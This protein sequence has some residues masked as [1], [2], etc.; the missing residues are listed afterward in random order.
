MAYYVVSNELYHHGILGQKWGIR[1][2][3]NPDGSLTEAGKKRYGESDSSSS[4]SYEKA[5]HN[6][7]KNRAI[8]RR[9]INDELNKNGKEL[10]ESDEKF[11]TLGDQLSKDYDNYYKKLVNDPDF[12]RQFALKIIRDTNHQLLS[13][14]EFDDAKWE[15]VWDNEFLYGK[16]PKEIKNKE[17]EFWDAGDKYFKIIDNATKTVVDRYRDAKIT[18]TYGFKTK[19]DELRVKNLIDS[20]VTDLGFNAYMYRHYYDYWV[21]QG[22]EG[23][24]NVHASLSYN[25]YKK[26]LIDLAV[27][28]DGK[29]NFS[30]SV[31]R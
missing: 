13:E 1:R 19:V 6:A 15:A 14:D 10:F 2:F 30:N 9:A 20:S 24:A 18:D 12:K 3:Q 11:N 8:V 27:G 16:L 17:S 31:K 21:S 29:N 23:P 25:D 4:T 26:A 7:S 22:G 28:L 5:G